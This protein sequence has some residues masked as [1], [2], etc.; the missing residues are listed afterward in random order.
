M[1]RMKKWVLVLMWAALLGFLLC[2]LI[3]S[4]R[5]EEREGWILCK[6]DSYVVARWSASKTGEI[7]GRLEMGDKIITDGQTKNGYLHCRGLTFESD[8]GWVYAG[9]IVWDEP[10]ET[11]DKTWVI[12]AGGRTAC[13]RW[14]DGPRRAWAKNHSEVTVYAIS[15]DWAVTNKGFI[16]VSCMEPKEDT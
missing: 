14:V 16:K 10:A 9:Y 12:N 7:L 2:C 4:A 13:R 1:K 5:A 11:T 3:D 15:N 8:E 6:P